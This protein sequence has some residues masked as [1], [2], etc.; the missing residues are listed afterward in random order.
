MKKIWRVIG[1]VSAFTAG[2]AASVSGISY[3]MFNQA[4]KRNNKPPVSAAKDSEENPFR[5]MYQKGKEWAADY[6]EVCTRLTIVNQGVKLVGYYYDQGSEK[7]VIFVHGYNSTYLERLN[8]A[9]LYYERGY[10]VLA[11]ICRGHGESAGAYRTMGYWDGRDVACWA[12]YL[13]AKHGQK[14][15]ILDGVSMGGATVLTAAGDERLP[16]QVVGIVSDC[17]Y[18]ATH[19]IFAYQLKKSMGIPA[20]PF[21]NIAEW[22]GRKI[23]GMSTIQGSPIESVEKAK[24]PVL[25]IHGVDDDFVPYEMCRQLQKACPTARGIFSVKGAG[26][27]DSC[28]VDPEGYKNAIEEFLDSLD[29]VENTEEGI[30]TVSEDMLEEIK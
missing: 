23:C 22:F 28:L 12:R 30:H 4:V 10:N 18:T 29:N 16:H 26:H 17:A 14:K 5:E 13:A 3:W 21:L 7:S 8:N 20:F 25:F 6:K 2:A 15:I 9:S 24:V 27:A 1:G 19:D 11:V